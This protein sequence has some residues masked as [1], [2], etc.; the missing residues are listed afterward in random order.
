MFGEDCLPS[1][2]LRGL[3]LRQSH[4]QDFSVSMRQE[5][6]SAAKSFDSRQIELPLP[7]Q[8][9]AIERRIGFGSP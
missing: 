7:A 1:C 6:G 9:S 3:K 2:K 4:M 8:E 5:F